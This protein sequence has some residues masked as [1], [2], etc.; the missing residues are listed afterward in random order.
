MLT[1]HSAMEVPGV[2]GI[3]LNGR[4]FASILHDQPRFLLEAAGE[5]VRI[6]P[7]THAAHALLDS[8]SGPR[9]ITSL[10]ALADEHSRRVHLA[11]VDPES[12]VLRGVALSMSPDGH[13]ANY[14]LLNML[15][16]AELAGS[17]RPAGYLPTLHHEAESGLLRSHPRVGTTNGFAGAGWIHLGSEPSA[18]LLDV[19]R[20]GIQSQPTPAAL[21]DLVSLVGHEDAHLL[22]PIPKDVLPQHKK[23]EEATTDLASWLP[24]EHHAIARAMD[25]PLATDVKITT[26]YE[27]LRATLK[28]YLRR[29]GVDVSD[30]TRSSEALRLLRGQRVD[31]F[32]RVLADRIAEHESM[33]RVGRWRLERQITDRL[34]RALPVPA[35]KRGEAPVAILSA[36]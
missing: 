3:T 22:S 15:E 18:T 20:G 36:Q 6:V 9:V 7:E 19:W 34:N 17:T 33:G 2:A 32:P 31:D 35:W 11:G 30:P 10:E 28:P 4:G 16:A 25:I 8:P 13:R 29:A 21:N 26:T 23:A 24:G 14:A 1:F 5:S 12:S 27:H